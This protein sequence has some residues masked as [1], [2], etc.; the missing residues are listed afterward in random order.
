MSNQ[1]GLF[2]SKL[3]KQANSKLTKSNST[4]FLYPLHSLLVRRLNKKEK[5]SN[6]ITN[7]INEYLNIPD[8]FFSPNS[9]VTIGKKI[10]LK[11]MRF[12]G[13]EPLAPKKM[14]PSSK[15]VSLF[16]KSQTYN[17]L[18]NINIGE[19][20][21]RSSISNHLLFK[22]KQNQLN[23]EK[24]DVIDNEQLKKIFNKY[25]TFQ[26]SRNNE[27]VLFNIDEKKNNIRNLNIYNNNYIIENNKKSRNKE[28]PIDIKESLTFQNN[29]LKI[30]ENVDNKMKNLSKYLS[31]LLHKNENKLL[32][33]QVDEY[34]I[35]KELLK[36]IEYNKP[37][38]EKYGI[39][40]WNISLRRPKHFEGM[41]NTYIN[42]TR[43][44]N[45]FWGI[46]VEKYPKIKEIKMRPGTLDKN[47][48]FFE[49]FKKSHSPLI[50]YKDYKNLENLD[51]LSV[52]GENLFNIEY[53]REIN[54]NRSKKKLY[55][56]FVDKGG[57]VILK[58]EI[59]NIFGEK[60]FYENYNSN[61]LLS[62]NNINFKSNNSGYNTFTNKLPFNIKNINNSNSS[63]NVKFFPNSSSIIN[64]KTLEKNKF[65]KNRSSAEI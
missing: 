46:V 23:N 30:K 9:R 65:P 28:I 32:I 50:N 57:K 36:E 31:K 38:D 61:N 41:R 25:K 15:R 16:R 1:G 26:N 52:K 45:P 12:I 18:N 53:N 14:T 43:D 56:A 22:D 8:K 34:C 63:L 27:N 47:K 49:K 2:K 60:T 64:E 3:L 55:K 21:L 4:N 33:N 5:S 58:T 40:K 13:I 11:D 48:N 35:K 37:M 51:T 62:S 24:Y 17:N 44:Q 29:K 54:N 10:K 59:N 7:E 20:N 6:F 19:V 42:L 39:Y